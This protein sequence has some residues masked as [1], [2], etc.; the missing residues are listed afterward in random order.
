MWIRV[1][2]WS[3]IIAGVGLL[4]AAAWVLLQPAVADDNLQLRDVLA[5]EQSGRW[6]VLGVLGALLGNVL[7]FLNLRIAAQ[8]TDAARV[9]A[10]A[11]L[12]AVNHARETSALELRP[13]V[14]N[15]HVHFTRWVVDGRIDNVTLRLTWRNVGKTPAKNFRTF[16]GWAAKP[17]DF[18]WSTFDFPERANWTVVGGQIGPEYEVFSNTHFNIPVEEFRRVNAGESSLIFWASMEYDGVDPTVRHRTETS[19]RLFA[20]GDPDV[21]GTP[22]NSRFLGLHHGFDAD[23]MYRPSSPPGSRSPLRSAPLQSAVDPIS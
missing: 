11:A 10:D 23:C 17:Q 3:A 12:E 21:E 8:A 2:I 9:A 13:Y 20:E 1:G 4:G 14:E 6:A 22:Y 16:I 5:S 18:D 19:G 15:T 7:L